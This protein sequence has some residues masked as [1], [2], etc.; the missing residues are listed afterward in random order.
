MKAGANN[1]GWVNASAVLTVLTLR[2]RIDCSADFK[3]TAGDL[4]ESTHQP[5]KLFLHFGFD[6]AFEHHRREWQFD[7]YQEFLVGGR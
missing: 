1:K 6:L 5:L 4:I 2:T 3:A 7:G